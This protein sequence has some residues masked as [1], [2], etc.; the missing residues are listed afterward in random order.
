LICVRGPFSLS[1]GLKLN[2]AAINEISVFPNPA[3]D[4]VAVQSDGITTSSLK[5]ELFDMSGRLIQTSSI[6]QGSPIAYFDTRN[7]F[8]GEYIIKVSSETELYIK[9]L[10]IT[11]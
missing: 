1:T 2:S 10:V 8:S 11:K 3:S 5:V 7:L 6:F 4:I 9:K